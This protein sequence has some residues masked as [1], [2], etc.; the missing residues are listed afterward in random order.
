MKTN[1]KLAIIFG[2]L[3]TGF[4]WVNTALAGSI[5]IGQTRDLN[6]DDN[7][8]ALTKEKSHKDTKFNVNWL[9]NTYDG[10]GFVPANLEPLGKWE[11]EKRDSGWE[12][13]AVW[14]G[15]SPY[16]N[17]N[18]S[19]TSGSWE[20]TDSWTGGAVYY[21]LKAGNKFGLY[22]AGS[23]LNDVTILWNTLGITKAKDLSHISFWTTDNPSGPD[24]VPEP[25]TIALFAIGLLMLAGLARKRVQPVSVK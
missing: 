10:T 20:T 13:G 19:G 21:S 25:S 9:V 23:D 11:I 16:F 14:G 12:S 18:S 22:Y 15:G 7:W 2:I 6:K 5:F 24:P 1:S 17:V 8:K 4:I 3:L